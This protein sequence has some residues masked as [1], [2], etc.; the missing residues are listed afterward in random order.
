MLAIMGPSGNNLRILSI[1]IIW[2][3]SLMFFFNTKIY[4]L[5]IY[6]GSGKT[7]LLAYLS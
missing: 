5:I 7:T 1:E 2:K 3:K 4:L 6:K